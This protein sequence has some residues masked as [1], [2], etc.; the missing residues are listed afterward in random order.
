MTAEM[1]LRHAVALA[2]GLLVGLE[3]GWRDREELP[4]ERIA[5]IR[6][7]AI[8]GLFGAAAG[9][10][11]R[12]TGSSGPLV[13]AMLTYGALF[14]ALQIRKALTENDYSITGILSGLLVILLGA[15]SVLGDF[16]LAAAGGV[17]LA[18]LLAGRQVLHALLM[19][20]TWIEIRSAIVLSAMTAI[21]LPLLPDRTLDPW[22]GFNPKQVWLFTVITAALS[23][24]GYIAARLT[25]PSKGALL[26]GLTG[27]LVSSTSVTVALARASAG[28]E[29]V[30]PLVAGACAAAMVSV[31]RVFVIV[32]L[33]RPALLAEIGPAA[34]AA[35][36]TLGC[37]AILPVLLKPDPEPA[38]DAPARNPFELAHLLL[39]AAAFAALS[40]LNAAIAGRLGVPSLIGSAAI[41]GMFDVDIAVM[42]TLRLEQAPSALGWAILGALASN[43]LGRLA[44]AIMSGPPRFSVPLALATAAATLAGVAARLLT[45]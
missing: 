26:T 10:L 21:V 24:L 36:I 34:G 2:I 17:T 40:T 30:W 44:L 31:L 11:T 13:A 28:Q 3:R 43:G 18:A 4:G 7:H 9:D 14:G 29:K 32:L 15:L 12:M 23:Y 8:T 41:S 6:T 45:G 37:A 1:M 33:L 20:V 25:G 5:G 27:G 35:A 42:S 39:L 22:G 38:G 19:R 16:R